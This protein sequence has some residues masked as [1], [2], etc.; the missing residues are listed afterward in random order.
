MEKEQ[1]GPILREIRYR[2][3]DE[4]MVRA[5][6]NPNGLGGSSWSNDLDRGA[7]LAQHLSSGTAWVNEHGA[8]QPDAPF[9]GVMQSGVGVESCCGRSAARRR[10]SLPRLHW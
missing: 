5:N 6:A 2:D 10:D 7:A 1:F 8:I 3:V 9:C 4:V